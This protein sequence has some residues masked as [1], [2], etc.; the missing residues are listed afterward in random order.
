M[1]PK[2]LVTLL[3]KFYMGI[4]EFGFQFVRNLDGSFVKSRVLTKLL[5]KF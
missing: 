3:S 1:P 2:A 4:Q 5:T